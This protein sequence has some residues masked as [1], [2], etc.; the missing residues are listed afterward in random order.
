MQIRGSMEHLDDLRFHNHLGKMELHNFDVN[1]N[2][3]NQ[4]VSN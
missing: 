2:Y 3:F 1:W 4:N